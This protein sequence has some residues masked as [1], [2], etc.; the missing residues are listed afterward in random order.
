ME[1]E[2]SGLQQA[3]THGL[4]VQEV[5]VEMGKPLQ[6]LGPGTSVQEPSDRQQTIGGAHGLGL[7]V[8]EGTNVP[9]VQ[10]PTLT[11]AQAPVCRLQHDPV[12]GLGL[13]VPPE[14]QVPFVHTLWET[15]AHA[16][17]WRLQHEPRQGLGWQGT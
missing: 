16:P 15:I 14:T 4:G 7:H 8:P 2:P 13:H 11:T 10:A 6:K 17:V 3:L 9:L 1:Q 12:H 5:R